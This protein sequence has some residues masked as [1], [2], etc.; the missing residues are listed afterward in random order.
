M[1]NGLNHWEVSRR[2]IIQAD[3]ELAAGDML[4]ASEKGWGAAAHAIK[5]VAQERGWRH[6]SHS[7]LF[8][9]ANRLASTTGMYE[10]PDLFQT[11]SETHKNFY[12]GNMSKEDVAG[13][14]ARIRT[15]LDILDNLSSETN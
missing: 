14:L 7:R 15:L 2:F 12:E 10:I 9:I 5:A 13:S 6:D 3:A 1:P 4:Q 8:G 11:A